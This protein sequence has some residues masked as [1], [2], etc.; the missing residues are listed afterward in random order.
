MRRWLAREHRAGRA[1][2]PATVAHLLGAGSLAATVAPAVVPIPPPIA[3]GRYALIVWPPRRRGDLLAR[4]LFFETR[5]EAEAAAPADMPW[6]VVDTTVQAKRR[7]IDS[8]E[9]DAYIRATRGQP[10]GEPI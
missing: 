10:P 8:R 6:S 5:G 7:H 4:W 2:R 3:G 1:G 9:V